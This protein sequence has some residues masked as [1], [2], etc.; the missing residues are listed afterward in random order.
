MKEHLHTFLKDITD[1]DIL[2]LLNE[3]ETVTRVKREPF[4]NSMLI[5][6]FQ[7]CL[8]PN[9]ADTE[10]VPIDKRKLDSTDDFSNS[11][12]LRKQI[13]K[14]QDTK[15]YWLCNEIAGLKG[16]SVEHVV[17]KRLY[18]FLNEYFKETKKKKKKKPINYMWR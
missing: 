4:K 3:M 6:Y 7:V 5:H 15:L 16:H 8:R 2:G 9:G 1:S 10:Q 11:F 18:V 17:G 13:N 14:L 12:C